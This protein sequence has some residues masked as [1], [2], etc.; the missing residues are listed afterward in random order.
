M[1]NESNF[2]CFWIWH[3]SGAQSHS[4]SNDNCTLTAFD[5]EFKK[6]GT[7]SCRPDYWFSNMWN[8]QNAQAHRMHQTYW[9]TWFT[10]F[11]WIVT[12]YMF[13]Q[14]ELN[15]AEIRNFPAKW[16]LTKCIRTSVFSI[17]STANRFII[18]NILW[19][20]QNRINFNRNHSCGFFYQHTLNI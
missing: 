8:M 9:F 10:Q 15:L 18:W 20:K 6:N 17:F 12:G 19:M 11:K 7:I 14:C 1:C 5:F 3:Q 2:V 16:R 13:P 4:H